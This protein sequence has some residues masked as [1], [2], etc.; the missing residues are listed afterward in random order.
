M[1]LLEK[2]ATE[3]TIVRFTATWCGPCKQMNP[4]IEELRQEGIQIVDVDI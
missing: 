2:I 3:D 4:I 1:D